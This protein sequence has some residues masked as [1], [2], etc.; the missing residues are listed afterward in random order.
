MLT[1]SNSP[2]IPDSSHFLPPVQIHVDTEI[3]LVTFIERRFIPDHVQLKSAAGRAHYHAILKH[4]LRPETVDRLFKPYIRTVRTRLQ[5]LP[6]W[7]YLDGLFLGELTSDHVSRLVASATRRGYSPQTVKHIKN[8]VSAILSHAQR[9]GLIIGRN[10]ASAVELPPM[11]RRKSHHLSLAQAKS[12]LNSTRDPQRIAALLTIVTGLSIADI[13]AL[14]W[15]HVDFTTSQLWVERRSVWRRNVS[16]R[17][18]LAEKS[19]SADSRKA[20][21]FPLSKTLLRTLHELKRNCHTTNPESCIVG[22]GSRIL[23]RPIDL[24]LKSVARQLHMPWLSWQVV[25]RAH[26]DLRSELMLQLA[27]DLLA[28]E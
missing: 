24:P 15:K 3:S 1:T 27:D 23:L 6:D 12:L 5:T 14:R 4:V 13:C 17:K 21:C 22:S 2:T 26:N 11:A 9:E 16:S 7:P 19:S 18:Y 10:P 28:P 8:V 25:R 20:E